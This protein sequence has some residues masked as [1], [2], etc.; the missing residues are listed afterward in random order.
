MVHQ[1]LLFR[2]SKDE[3]D[4]QVTFLEYTK[5]LDDHVNYEGLLLVSDEFYTF[6]QGIENEVRKILTINFLIP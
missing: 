5:T 2:G 1:L 4:K 6:V 3:L